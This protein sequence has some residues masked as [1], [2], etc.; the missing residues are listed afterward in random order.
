MIVWARVSVVLFALF[1]SHSYPDLH[2]MFAKILS[3][4]NLEFLMVWVGTGAVFA[5]LV[6]AISVV[7]VP[8]MLDRGSDTMESIVASAQALWNNGPAMLLWALCIVVL[9]GV[10][11][12]VFLPLLLITA[13]L[14]GHGT[15]HAYKSLVVTR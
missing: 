7:S 12:A 1:G 2:D 3:A 4:E 5:A 15:W 13:P 6:F 9:I 10:S 11:L 14:V 8:M